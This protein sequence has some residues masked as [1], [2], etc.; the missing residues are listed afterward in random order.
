MSPS[1][2]TQSKA[3]RY[4]AERRLR[5]EGVG[6]SRMLG[7]VV[8]ASCRGG[9]DTVYALGFEAGEWWCSC[10]ARMLCAHLVALPAVVAE[11]AAPELPEAA[12][13][14]AAA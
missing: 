1:E 6:R 7:F 12:A 2:T 8:A 11:P 14:A 4:L 3:L 10:P 13:M 5:V 9:D